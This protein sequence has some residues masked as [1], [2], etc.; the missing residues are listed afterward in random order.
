MFKKEIQLSQETVR[1]FVAAAC[2]CD[3]AIDL[4]YDRTVVNAKSIM[5]VFSMDL[6]NKLTVVYQGRD[7][8]FESVLN[9][10]AAA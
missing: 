9:Q 10:L 7:E 6:S 3:F 8:E 4:C 5:G 2:K 1:G